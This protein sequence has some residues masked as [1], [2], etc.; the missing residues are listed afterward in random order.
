MSLLSIIQAQAWV[1]GDAH[2]ASSMSS[3]R[4][5]V[6]SY[7]AHISHTGLRAAPG[8]GM[9]WNDI[10]WHVVIKMMAGISGILTL[11]QVPAR[12]L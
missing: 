9:A 6:V 10:Y 7:I 8:M 11:C 5:D 2:L 1:L 12:G 3:L 4:P